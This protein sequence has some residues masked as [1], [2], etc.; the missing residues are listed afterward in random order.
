MSIINYK[1]INGD[2]MRKYYLF[3]IR[4]EFYNVYKK[5]SYVLYKTLENLYSLKKENLQYGV[6]LFNQICNLIDKDNIHS[7]FS[8]YIKINENKYLVNEK[9]EETIITIRNPYIL[10]NTNMNFPPSMAKLYSDN[11]FI[12]VIDFK[13]KDYF[14]LDEHIVIKSKYTLI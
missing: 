8:E 12:F 13:N 4:R 1:I 2:N 6:A 11:K 10:Y 9:K 5:N 3:S 7:I 14:W